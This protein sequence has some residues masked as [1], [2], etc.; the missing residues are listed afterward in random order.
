MVDYDP[1]SA[2]WYDPVNLNAPEL[3]AQDGLTPSEGNPQFHQQMVYAVASNTIASFERALGRSIFWA[4]KQFRMRK[5]LSNKEDDFIQ[6]LRI[7][8]HALRTAN[9]YYSPDK[10]ALLFGYFRSPMGIVFT[11]LSHDIVAHETTHAILDGM[12]RRYIEDN[13]E[14][15]LAFHEAFADIVALFQHFSFPEVLRH[16]IA[17]TRGNLLNE[18]ILGEL[19]QEF[20]EATGRYGAL[21]SAIGMRDEAGKWQPR[22]PDPTILTKTMEPHERGAVL[23]AA[24]FSAFTSIYHSR[25][26]DLFRIASNGR[27]AVDGDLHPDLVDRLASEASKTAKQFLTI[28]IR[29]LDYAPPVEITFGD[30]LRALVT[31]DYD[32]VPNDPYG[33]RTALIESFRKWGIVAENVRTFSEDQLR[34]P[35]ARPQFGDA[36]IPAAQLLRSVVSKS[37]YFQNRE[38]AYY[39][40]KKA[41]KDL[42]E[43]IKKNLLNGGHPE[44]RESFEDITGINISEETEVEGVTYDRSGMGK[45]EVHSIRP[46]LRVSPDGVIIKQVIITITQRRKVSL[47]STGGETN[48]TFIFRG[49]TTL[50]LDLEDLTIR[51]A[52]TRP[53][54][55]DARLER[56]KR[57]RGAKVERQ[58]SLREMY[59]GRGPSDSQEADE[60]YGA[61]EPFAF[62]H[63]D[64]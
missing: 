51:Y 38:E 45:F 9:A 28:C 32:M 42:H 50:I 8:P 29:A 5:D 56:V 37:L 21:R 24:V 35:V 55:D 20:G 34:W 49:G 62:L 46:A 2:C 44:I 33:Y 13:H 26:A 18:N 53:I 17:R 4:E 12:H 52:I 43:E 60:V 16:Q 31:A 54:W 61:Y 23:V 3:L 22:I 19:A 7:Y 25:V 47:V 63:G 1:A 15:T 11:C 27:G 57:Y 36:F 6:R 41:Q 64:E 48:T 58:M 30:Y 39:E 10:K 59:F 40:L 14:D